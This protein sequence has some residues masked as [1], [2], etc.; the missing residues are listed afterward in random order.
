MYALARHAIC[1]AGIPDV[2]SREDT[3]TDNMLKH[4]VDSELKGRDFLCPVGRLT[5]TSRP[6]GSSK[7]IPARFIVPGILVSN[8][9]FIESE[10]SNPLSNTSFLHCNLIGTP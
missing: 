10:Y 3:Y 4:F 5:N 9:L 7:L 8:T 6:S 2:R 1:Y